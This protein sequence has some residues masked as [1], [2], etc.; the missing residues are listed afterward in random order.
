ME[1]ALGRR[2]GGR[3]HPDRPRPPARVWRD[4]A[5]VAVFTPMA[6]LEGLLR[7]DLPWRPVAL[8]IGVGLVPTLLWRRTRPFLMTAIAF[9]V[10]IV[11]SLAT[12]GPPPELNSMFY[13]LLFPYALAR[14][15]EGRAVPAGLSIAVLADVVSFVA[16]PESLGSAAG[17]L[18]VL[19]T[20]AA[21]GAAFRYRAWARFREFEQV[22]LVER[23]RLARDLHDTVAHHVSAIA[24]RAQA[25]LA[26]A[27]ARQEAAT[28]ALRLIETEAR[29]TLAEM[30]TMVRVLRRDQPLTA[31]GSS[32]P[33]APPLG[34]PGPLAGP[35]PPRP[36]DL[37]PTPGITDLGRLA[38]DRA[39]LPVAVS[40]A[41]PVDDVAAPVATAVYRLAQEAVTNARRHARG[42]TGIEVEVTADDGAVRLRVRDDGDTS[43]A[44][45]S[46]TPGYGLLGMRERVH[47]LGGTFEAGPEQR[48]G[49]RGGWTVH[50][51]LPRAGAPA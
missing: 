30:R 39:G 5:L 25:G 26:T 44:A 45:P 43:G 2:A 23:E 1:A 38:D 48:P 42:A 9:G 6:L 46:P 49:A 11:A 34:G 20:S 10:G 51:V 7:P 24:I 37:A 15:G 22:K 29:R 14:W 47:L 8:V 12:S 17:G 36:E 21:L 28:E 40:L 50:A 19:T 27:P 35:T 32:L 4:W 31:T 18:A 41:G 16:D 33:V 13:L 3:D